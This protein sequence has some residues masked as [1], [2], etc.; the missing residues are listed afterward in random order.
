MGDL[1]WPRRLA[2]PGAEGPHFLYSEAGPEVGFWPCRTRPTRGFRG[3]QDTLRN[4]CARVTMKQGSSSRRGRP[5]SGGK[6]HPSSRIHSVESTGPDVKVRGSAQQVLDKYLA[7]ARDAISAGNRV[8]AEGYFQYAD[9]Y[10]RLVNGVGGG[11]N[12]QGRPD[13]GPRGPEAPAPSR[14]RRSDGRTLRG[15]VRR[16]RDDHR[17]AA[18]IRTRNLPRLVEKRYVGGASASPTAMPP[19]ATTAA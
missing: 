19:P 11:P 14:S 4:H 18:K 12:G 15:R 6:R 16:R 9:H 1:W 5:R 10:Y 3:K 13:R 8:E 7:L 2:S 17:V